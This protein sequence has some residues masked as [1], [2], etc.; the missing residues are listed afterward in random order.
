MQPWALQSEAAPSPPTSI[1]CITKAVVGTAVGITVADVPKT[2]TT[3]EVTVAGVPKTGTAVGVA[4]AGVPE[5][6]PQT[7]HIEFAWKPGF[8]LS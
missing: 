7:Q 1:F 8:D 4:V 6:P 2:G 5:P 3:V